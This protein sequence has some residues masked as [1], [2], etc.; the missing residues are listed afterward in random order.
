MSRLATLPQTS[1]VVR[2]PAPPIAQGPPRVF[3]AVLAMAVL[4]G[5][6]YLVIGR[7]FAAVLETPFLPYCLLG[8]F[9]IHIWTRPG[10]AEMVATLTLAIAAAMAFIALSGRYRF[11]WPSS[12][13]CGSFSDL[14]ASP[15]SPSRRF[16]IVARLRR[17]D[18]LL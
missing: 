10:R 18:W 2:P 6:A 14:P 1:L 4:C 16:A 3:A 15:C 12:I 11:D 17:L 7:N 5:Q 13:A 8:A 9:A